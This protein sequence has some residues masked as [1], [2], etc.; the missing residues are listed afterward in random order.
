MTCELKSKDLEIAR[1]KEEDCPD[2]ISKRILRGLKEEV[3]QRYQ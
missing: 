2:E 3:A 1:A